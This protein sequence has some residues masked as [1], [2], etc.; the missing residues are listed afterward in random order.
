MTHTNTFT[1]ST[2]RSISRVAA[3]LAILTAVSVS[4]RAQASDQLIVDVGERIDLRDSEGL[5]LSGNWARAYPAAGGGWDLFITGGDTYNV[6]KMDADFNVVSDRQRLVTDWPHRLVD[7]Q[8]T[9]CPD[10]SW[11]HVASA[12]VDRPNDSAYLFRYDADFNMVCNATVGERDPVYSYNDAPLICTGGLSETDPMDGTATHSEREDL[13]KAPF[14]FFDADCNQTHSEPHPI[15]PSPSGSSIIHDEAGGYFWQIR[16]TPDDFPVLFQLYSDWMTPVDKSVTIDTLVPEGFT[17][18]WPQAAIPVGDYYVVAHLARDPSIIYNADK[19]DVWV[20]VFNRDLEHL[21]AVRITEF[22][23]GE[24][25]QRPWLSVRDNTLVLVYDHDLWPRLVP[26]TLDA[27]MLGLEGEEPDDTTEP[28]EDGD[29]GFADDIDPAEG[30]DDNE[31]DPA[32]PEASSDSSTA[33]GS[34]GCSTVSKGAPVGALF[35]AGLGLVAVG[36]RRQ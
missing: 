7:H 26:I 31:S 32:R 27:E 8:I 35:A 1:D 5:E 20:Q 4:N 30:D 29:S 21:Q 23:D 16:T 2:P 36:R 3:G 11:L 33:R 17:T 18:H 13:E 24:G 6:M 34:S 19:G 14:L 15:R 9:Q 28:E 10:G 25:A 12:N 22:T